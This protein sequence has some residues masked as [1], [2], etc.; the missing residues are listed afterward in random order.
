MNELNLETSPYLLQHAQNPV[1][2]KSWNEQTLQ[3]AKGQ[4]KLLLISIGYST[5]H[6]C[7]VMEHESFESEH[8]A[9]V[10]NAH[11]VNI[12]IDREERP[13]IDAIYMN[14]VQIMTGR[15]GWPLN[16]VC[17]PDG[18]P[19]WGGTYFRKNEWIDTLQQLQELFENQP[20][21]LYEYAQKLTDG[22]A[23]LQITA[24]KPKEDAA[25]FS[26]EKLVEKWQKSFDWEFGGM[27]RAPKFMMP[28]NYLFLMRYAFE[29]KDES[30][31]NFVDLTL[32]KMAQGGI[33]DTIHGGFSRYSVDLKWH[34]PH[35]EKMLYDNGQLLSLYS[36][37]YKY[38]KKDL[39][40]EII[41]KT[42][43]F[44]EAD[45]LANNGGF[46]SALDADSMTIDGVLEEGAFYVWTKEELQELL[47]DDF[48][49]FSH[50]YNINDFGFWEQGNF[51]LIQNQSLEI[52]AQNH[53]IS[54]DEL[55]QK[56]NK[57]EVVLL[58]K[59][60]LRSKPRLDDK[61]LTSWNAITIT[62]LVDAWMALGN[63]HYLNIALQ[64]AQFIID[65]LIDE[66]GNLY[67]N[68]K[69][70]KCS[71]PA[72]LDDY[73]L[74][75]QAFLSCYKATCDEKYL[76]FSKKLNDQVMDLF[77]DESQGFFTYKSRLDTQLIANQFEIEDN[78]IPSSNAIMAQNLLQLGILYEDRTYEAVAK[79]MLEVT[80]SHINYPSAYSQWLQVYLDTTS[81][82]S[83]IVVSG[84]DIR[85]YLK[86]L[87][88]QYLPNSFIVGNISNSEIPH[89]VGKFQEDQGSIY[90]C[91][92]QMCWPPIND[93]A[94]LNDLL[95]K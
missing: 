30:L 8:V 28:N 2:W 10:M 3:K 45:F 62:G 44:L 4:N 82:F 37:A 40:K 39:Y 38:F 53:N 19:V 89:F 18:R 34:V 25:I 72:F 29:T 15:G 51:V 63:D 68:Y 5:C 77:F 91:K 57:W 59:R 33:F 55:L 78:V 12:K 84:K 49:L 73:A 90:L 60:N 54:F 61:I 21:R 16:V 35:F 86:D 36:Q 58:Q 67:R 74:T 87:Q 83:E 27:A 71:I 11:F 14:A 70:G 80:L 64:N 95:K 1:H 48:H 79:K 52:I 20:N 88:E 76:D 66:N 85:N 94:I 41:E 23:G 7:H 46:Y 9:E 75:I 50:V 42:V 43:K 93:L 26:V 92:D 65:H 81:N 32:T 69:D 17:L 56:R 13:D 47:K 22:I 31:M 6:W 24:T